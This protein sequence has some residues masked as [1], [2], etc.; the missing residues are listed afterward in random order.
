MGFVSDSNTPPTPATGLGDTS[1]GQIALVGEF[2]GQGASG[3]C[4][5]SWP[6]SM[7]AWRARLC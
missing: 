1:Q 7:L 2:R 4:C 3:L 6:V 5:L